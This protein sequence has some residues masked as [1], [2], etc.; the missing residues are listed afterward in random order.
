MF[1]DHLHEI[2]SG[3]HYPFLQ[4]PNGLSLKFQDLSEVTVNG[5]D[6]INPGDVVSLIGD[7]DIESI[8]CLLQ[9]LSKG[10]IVVPLTIDTASQHDYFMSESY[11]QYVF[12]KNRFNPA[13]FGPT[14]TYQ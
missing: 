4:I 12:I 10:A 8:A 11:S 5:I 13:S 3:I 1:I 6:E 9:L 7:F 2:W 14:N